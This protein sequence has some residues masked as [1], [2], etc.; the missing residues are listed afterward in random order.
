MRKPSPKTPKPKPLATATS[1]LR[2]MG[3]AIDEIQQEDE[4]PTAG[5]RKAYG[6]KATNR[7]TSPAKIKRVPVFQD[8]SEQ[9]NDTRRK[10]NSSKTAHD[11]DLRRMHTELSRNKRF[12]HQTELELST[13]DDVCSLRLHHN[14]SLR[15]TEPCSQ[16]W[17]AQNQAAGELRRLQNV[18]R[19]HTTGHTQIESPARKHTPWFRG[20]RGRGVK[21]LPSMEESSSSSDSED[22]NT[23][24]LIPVTDFL[25]W[26]KVQF[27]SLQEAFEFLDADHN[28]SLSKKE[29]IS[30]L[31]R[32]HF[33][34]NKEA[35]FNLLDKDGSGYV[36][37]HEF[38][39]LAP[40]FKKMLRSLAMAQKK[41]R[42]TCNPGGQSVLGRGS[43]AALTH[44]LEK[45]ALP[46]M[47]IRPTCSIRLF[48]NADAKHRGTTLLLKHTPRDMVL[49]YELCMKVC[50]PLSGKVVALYDI[51]LQRVKAPL[52][53]VHE[54]K[55]VVCGGEGLVPPEAFWDF[56]CSQGEKLM[57]QRIA[58]MTPGAMHE[59]KK[60][61]KI[62]RSS[63]CP[64]KP[65]SVDLS[66]SLPQLS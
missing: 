35:L 58:D 49:L 24:E 10:Q 27:H 4:V 5:P 16:A 62:K 46:R 36:S 17:M 7:D 64:A 22:R 8:F 31:T 40:H 54:G 44:T 57:R 37:L 66:L 41:L 50:S 51:K 38:R 1:L 42:R 55:Y 45:Q 12:F 19:P 61:L 59:P 33:K 9:W 11:R 2:K 20:Q 39:N 43:V 14:A 52:E 30:A 13:I 32:G 47:S 3:E 56:M 28:S 60:K 21:A 6:T 23:S 29:W 15:K 65:K 25:M 63:S 48:R 26:I 53:L 18:L 34:G